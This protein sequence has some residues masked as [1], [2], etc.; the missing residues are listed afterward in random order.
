MSITADDLPCTFDPELFFSGR[1]RDKAEAI[2][3]CKTMC[4]RPAECLAECL[5]YEHISGETMAGIHGGTT[6]EE[7]NRLKGK[8]R[9]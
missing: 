2:R 9:R 3:L 6:P 5:E 7:R 4:P 8:A 1:A